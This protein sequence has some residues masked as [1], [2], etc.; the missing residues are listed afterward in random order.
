MSPSLRLNVARATTDKVW[1]RDSSEVHFRFSRKVLS[2]HSTV[3]GDMFET[4][5]AEGDADEVALAEPRE[6]LEVV[7]SYCGA[8]QVVPIDCFGEAFW[9]V[10]KAFNKYDVSLR[11]LWASVHFLLGD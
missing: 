2:A 4:A 8:E 9:Q 3:F 5:T 1:L 11:V 6:V 10:T 7:L